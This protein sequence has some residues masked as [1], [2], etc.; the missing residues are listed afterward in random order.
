MAGYREKAVQ[1]LA[2]LPRFRNPEKELKKLNIPVLLPFYHAVSDEPLAYLK[3]L[4]PIKSVQSFREDLEFLLQHFHPIDLAQLNDAIQGKISFKRL[5][6][7]MSFDD[8]LFNVKEVIAPILRDYGIPAVFFVNS[9]FT[10]QEDIFFR[11]KASLVVE[12]LENQDTL[13]S[14]A[15]AS[16]LVDEWHPEQLKNK[17][18][19]ATYKDRLWLNEVAHLL[20]LDFDEYLNR[21]KLYLDIQDLKELIDQGHAVGAHSVDHPRFE[22]ISEK[23]QLKQCVKSAKFIQQHLPQEQVVFSF[24]FSDYG[25]KDSFYQKVLAE[26]AL[27]NF[28]GSAGLRPN[29]GSLLQRVPMEQGNLSAA[30]ILSAEIRYLKIKKLLG[31]V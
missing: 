9:K 26:I 24:P 14:E 4:Y 18:L 6:F 30:E 20:G 22:F 15:M 28:F 23:K 7:L 2:K 25:V 19:E 27:D 12:H 31:R 13:D 11:Y 16:F 10:N 1:T 8:G 29:K 3:H 17:I 5:P 21:N